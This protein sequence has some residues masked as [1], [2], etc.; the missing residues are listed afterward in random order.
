MRKLFVTLFLAVSMTAASAQS[1]EDLA[2]Q[3]SSSR[4]ELSY[5]C[6]VGNEAPVHFSGRLTAQG[7]CY[8]LTGNGMDIWCDGSTRWSVDPEAKEVYIESSNGVEEVLAYQKSISEVSLTDVVITTDPAEGKFSFDIS[9]LD[10]S[11]V[12]TDLRQ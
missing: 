4:I 1:I 12:I 3:L 6:L 5:D 11:W 2:A 7:N 8:H 10:N 9:N